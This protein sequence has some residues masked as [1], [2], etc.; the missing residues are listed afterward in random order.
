M[1][2]MDYELYKY[3]DEL[4][5]RYVEFDE[6]LKRNHLTLT[7]AQQ[8][9][10]QFRE[11]FYALLAKY[12]IQ[13]QNLV[14]I[15]CNLMERIHQQS[16]NPDLQYLYFCMVTDFGLLVRTDPDPTNE[17]IIRN[18]FHQQEALQE[19]I[20]FCKIQ[21][22]NFRKYRELLEYLKKPIKMK[23]AEY[24][25]E[26]ELLYHLT[27]QHTFLYESAGNEIYRENLNALLTY[28]NSDK[29]LRL[30]K[31]YLIFAVLARK[32]GMM[33]NRPH[34]MPN[35]KAIFQYQDYSI[36]KD[37]GKNFNCYQSELE[38]YDH[39]QRSY[40]D[41]DDVDMEL[42]DFCFANLSPLSEWYY[43]NCEPNENIPMRLSRK[44]RTVMPKSF[45]DILSYEDYE[46]MTENELMIYGD[47]ALELKEK[48]LQISE[49]FLKI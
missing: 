45:P 38:L 26:S 23:N 36:Y 10:E 11:E 4:A 12:S 44:I 8:Q 27:I 21:N 2:D 15:C 25:E 48:M 29:T 22:E 5:D 6:L 43:M 35:L 1:Y 28:I 32:T 41:D 19:L 16:D 46:K 14:V 24:V 13:N 9:A 34:F 3:I 33:Q 17:Q 18:Y 42:C 37:N 47:A 30:V 39:L 7:E 20:D 49:E 31:L 40:M